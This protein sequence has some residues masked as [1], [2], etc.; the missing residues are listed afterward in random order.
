MNLFYL[1][2]I[3]KKSGAAFPH[4]SRLCLWS[5]IISEQYLFSDIGT[6][7]RNSQLARWSDD[8]IMRR[9]WRDDETLRWRWCN[10]A[11]TMV[12]WW[13]SDVLSCYPYRIIAPSLHSTIA[14]MSTFFA[15]KWCQMWIFIRHTNGD[16]K[17]GKIGSFFYSG[18]AYFHYLL[19]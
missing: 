10:N 12:R 7:S 16:F 3:F 8:A 15:R 19:L 18:K 6:R 2:L 1:I 5:C 11:I 14:T 4:I 9:R 17:R 13:W